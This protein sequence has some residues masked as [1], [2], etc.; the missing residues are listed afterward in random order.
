MSTYSEKVVFRVKV[1][2]CR[3]LSHAENDEE[4]KQVCI[5]QSK[6]LEAV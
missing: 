3:I 1:C 4:E 6:N 5:Q 2:T